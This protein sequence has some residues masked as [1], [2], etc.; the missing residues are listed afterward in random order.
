MAISFKENLEISQP[1]V[2]EYDKEEFIL[3]LKEQV[4]YYSLTSS[5]SMSNTTGTV[6]NLTENSH[7]FNFDSVINKHDTRSLILCPVFTISKHGT[8][9]TNT[10]PESAFTRF[11][12]YDMYA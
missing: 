1:T 9:T 7:L 6:F 11:K 8:A 3:A 2:T 10:S 4:A 5:F 12:E